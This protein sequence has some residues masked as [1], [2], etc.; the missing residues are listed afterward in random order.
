MASEN[1]KFKFSRNSITQ[2]LTAKNL[3]IFA[4]GIFAGHLIGKH[5]I[6]KRAAA[7]RAKMMMQQQAQQPM[8]VSAGPLI[9]DAMPAAMPASM[10]G[11]GGFEDMTLEGLADMSCGNAPCGPCSQNKAASTMDH[12]A[13]ELEYL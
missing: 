4:I 10:T 5:L 13:E 2:H 3:L 9:A 7:A 11:M 1:P 8:M 6:K 12:P